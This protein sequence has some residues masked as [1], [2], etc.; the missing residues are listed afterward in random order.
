MPLIRKRSK[1]KMTM[2]RMNPIATTILA[3]HGWDWFAPS[4]PWPSSRRS[5]ST[6]SFIRNATIATFEL[7]KYRLSRIINRTIS[8]IRNDAVEVEVA[9]INAGSFSRDVVLTCALKRVPRD[10]TVCCGTFTRP[11]EVL[12][13][14]RWVWPSSSST[15]HHPRFIQSEMKQSFDSIG[16]RLWRSSCRISCR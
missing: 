6:C 16:R 11:W 3:I 7:A 5:S 1:T 8:T 10:A 9:W 2:T 15:I 14:L 13:D 12:S 4:I